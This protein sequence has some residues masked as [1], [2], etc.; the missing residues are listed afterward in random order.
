MNNEVR[1]YQSTLEIRAETDDSRTI[2]G[3]P[4]VFDKASQDLGGFIEY[5]SKRALDNVDLSNVY[6]VY[7]HDIN[8]VLARAD[9]GTLKLEVDKVG[10]KFSATLPK[11]TLADDV[12]ENIRVGNIQGMSFG[13]TV[14]DD[15]WQWGANG[16]P[17]VRTIEKLDKLFE[18]TLTPMP[19]Y[20]D[21][22]VALSKRDAKHEETNKNIQIRNLLELQ[23]LKYRSSELN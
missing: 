6:L 13:F 3:Y 5:V 23:I 20:P 12:L 16:K 8:N 7:G 15:S 9:A 19:A 11:T 2:E 17:D 1:S 22:K 21:T 10:L 14:A 4:I 18:I